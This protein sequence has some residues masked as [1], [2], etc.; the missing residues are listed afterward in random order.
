VSVEES[1][2]SSEESSVSQLNDAISKVKSFF[3]KVLAKKHKFL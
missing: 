2:E 3:N 1:E